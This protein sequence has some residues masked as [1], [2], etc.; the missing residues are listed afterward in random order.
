MTS[1]QT[2]CCPYLGSP[3]ELFSSSFAFSSSAMDFFLPLPLLLLSLGEEG[4]RC[5]V[6][7]CELLLSEI[8]TIDGVASTTGSVIEK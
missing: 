7:C 8:G 4:R 5:F 6:S 3:C 1:I 2:S